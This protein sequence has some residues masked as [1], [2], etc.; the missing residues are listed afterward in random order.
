[1]M[2]PRNIR[3]CQICPSGYKELGWG[4]IGNIMFVGQCPSPSNIYGLKGTTK[5]DVEFFE[6]MG[7]AK[8]NDTD[9][10]FTNLVKTPCDITKVD[11]QTLEHCASHVLDEYKY[12]NPKLVI[13]LGSW[14][15]RWVGSHLPN[16]EHMIHPAALRYQRSMSKV[17]WAHNLQHIIKKNL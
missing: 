2:Y 11:Y 9:F 1:M 8:V 13:T 17:D 14:A 6:L 3:D 4:Q 5:F 15:K 16:S 10:F 12:V 7:L